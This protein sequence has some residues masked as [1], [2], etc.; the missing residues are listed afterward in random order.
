LAAQK[1]AAAPSPGVPANP[2]PGVPQNS[3]HPVEPPPRTGAELPKIDIAV[4]DAAADAM[5]RF[6]TA[7]QFAALHKLC[8]ILMPPVSKTPGALQAGAPE[9]LDFLIGHSSTERQHLYRTGLDALNAQ[10]FA[11]IDDSQAAAIL[12]PLQQLWTYEPPYDP[13]ARFLLTAKA[14]VRTATVNSREYGKIAA[15]T[16]RRGY[17]GGLYWYPLD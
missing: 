2:A 1:P 8:G 15:A 16:S 12:K 5:P 3:T 9:F 13:L 11:N 17:G 7:E 10:A 4:P 6:F 14:D